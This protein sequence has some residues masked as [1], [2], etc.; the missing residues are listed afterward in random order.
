[1]A[2]VS[3]PGLRQRLLSSLAGSRLPAD[4]VREARLGVHGDVPP[5]LAR[6]EQPKSAAVL[7]PVVDHVDAL[8]VMLTVR[9]DDLPDHPGQ[10]SFPGGSFEAHDRDA[11]AT[12]L[13]EM[14]EEVGVG[15]EAVTVSGY[16]PPYLTITGFAVAP[17]VGLL[18]P[19]YQARP[20]PS[21]VA[22]VFEAPLSFL[23]DPANHE[24]VRMSV[25]GH[26][27]AYYQIDWQ[28]YRIWGATAAMLVGL[29]QVLRP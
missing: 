9:T 10:I 24:I 13:R 29:S 5:S 27:L 20:D 26:D 21:E 12:A 2:T 16:L 7:V 6:V 1:M 14:E 4:L 15:A 17:V 19:D 28:G 23:M 8:T 18:R 11:V 22:E 25:R 3:D